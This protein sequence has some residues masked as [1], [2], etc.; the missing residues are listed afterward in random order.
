MAESPGKAEQIV[1]VAE[2]L[3]RTNG[4]NGFSFREIASEVGIKSASVHYHFPT[5]ADLGAAVARR[6]TERFLAGLGAPDDPASSPEALL[7]RYIN[8][9]R[10]ALIDEDLMCLCGVLGAEVDS[11]PPE[12]ALEAR[13]FFER[14]LEW[15]ETVLSRIH[16]DGSGGFEATG[17]RALK[18]VAALEGAMILARNLGRND[19]F[20]QVITDLAIA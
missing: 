11:L 9:Y 13:H 10:C 8:A 15:L 16:D 2:R 3:V 19:V 5:K 4:Y 14:N 17:R 7:Q 12:V 6:Y 1:T 20:E 18:I